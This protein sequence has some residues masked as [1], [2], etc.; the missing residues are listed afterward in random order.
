MFGGTGGVIP[1]QEAAQVSANWPTGNINLRMGNYLLQAQQK[2]TITPVADA[3][4]YPGS[5]YFKITI[6]GTDRALAVSPDAEL[7]TVAAFTGGPE[8]LWRFDQLADGSWR[9]MPK[10]VPGS[11]QAL[12]LTA[13]GSSFPTLEKFD[14]K[15]VKQRWLLKT[16]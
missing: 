9:I 10:S 15:N 3:G 12:A 11:T 8:Q 16:P 13:L 6:A 14:A 5:P 7:L 4:G 2:W 1:N